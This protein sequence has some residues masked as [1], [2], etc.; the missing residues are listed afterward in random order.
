MRMCMC[1]C[2]CMCICMCIC[3]CMCMCT[4]MDVCIVHAKKMYIIGIVSL[5]VTHTQAWSA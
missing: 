3:M 2:M 4:C 5:T 1:M